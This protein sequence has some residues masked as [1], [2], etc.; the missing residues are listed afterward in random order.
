MAW[1]EVVEVR[2]CQILIAADEGFDI[3]SAG[4]G[5]QVVIVWIPA[6]RGDFVRIADVLGT[7]PDGP[8]VSFGLLH[9]DP[10]AETIPCQHGLELVK[11]P[12]GGDQ[13]D[14]ASIDRCEKGARAATRSE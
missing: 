7:P 13:D 11:E 5:N 8:H 14:L 6:H 2:G 3:G 12:W 4:Q 10:G 1:H 9:R